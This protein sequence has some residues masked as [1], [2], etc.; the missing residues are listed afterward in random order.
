MAKTPIM[1]GRSARLRFGFLL[2][3]GILTS[4]PVVY[5]QYPLQYPSKSQVGK[6]GTAVLLEDYSNPPLSTSTHR[7]A[8]PPPI[9][10]K[11]QIGR[12]KSLR[13]KP[14]KTPLRASRFFCDEQSRSL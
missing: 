9:H 13:S 1:T 14:A 5:A 7:G 6:D 11:R 3:A 4:A 12:I 8:P 2:L 10:F